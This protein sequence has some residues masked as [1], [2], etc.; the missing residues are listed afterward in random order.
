MTNHDASETPVTCPTIY[1]ASTHWGQNLLW[2][3]VGLRT[4][5]PQKGQSLLPSVQSHV[6]SRV[7][8]TLGHSWACDCD[9]FFF[10]RENGFKFNCRLKEKGWGGAAGEEGLEQKEKSRGLINCFNLKRLQSNGW[11]TE[12][13]ASR[14]CGN[15]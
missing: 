15:K 10:C 2:A 11:K 1:K 6:S 12:L 5:T 8:L 4:H 13:C 14:K 3:Q 7:P 9:Q